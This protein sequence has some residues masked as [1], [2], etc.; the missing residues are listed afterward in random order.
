MPFNQLCF[1]KL[2]SP[3][4]ALL[5]TL[6]ISPLPSECQAKSRSEGSEQVAKR[7][8]EQT[9]LTT[10]HGGCIFIVCFS[11]CCLARILLNSGLSVLQS[12]FA[13]QSFYF[14]LCISVCLSL[15]VPLLIVAKAGFARLS[16]APKG[17]AI[18][19]STLRLLEDLS[20]ATF[21]AKL[22]CVLYFLLAFPYARER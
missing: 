15:C 9:T 8:H 7:Q 21:C 1:P 18:T 19:R 16:T 5:G 6:C 17:S 10:S 22:G 14:C 12:R 13:Y 11:P 4:K 20:L 3:S 2:S